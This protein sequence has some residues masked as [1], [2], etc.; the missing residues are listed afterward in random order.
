[1][2]QNVFEQ[3]TTILSLIALEQTDHDFM[4]MCVSRYDDKVGDDL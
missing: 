4:G 2:I 1:M 3:T